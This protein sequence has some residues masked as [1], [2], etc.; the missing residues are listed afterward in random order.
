VLEKAD[1]PTV[2]CCCCL[3]D[4]DAA[5]AVAMVMLSMPTA[6]ILILVLLAPPCEADAED[7][8]NDCPAA[9]PPRCAATT[10]PRGYP[11]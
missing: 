2:A 5:A 9:G 7:D 10:P 6:G 4:V 8:G 11:R 1:A 3:V